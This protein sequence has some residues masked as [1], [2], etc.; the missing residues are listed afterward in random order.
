[1][2]SVA[3]IVVSLLVGFAM[4]TLWHYALLWWVSYL[5]RRSKSTK[6]K[7][8]VKTPLTSQDEEEQSDYLLQ[9]ACTWRP[10]ERKILLGRQLI[11]RGS[12][13]DPVENALMRHKR[14]MNAAEVTRA[15]AVVGVRLT[16]MSVVI[17]LE[18][19]VVLHKAKRKKSRQGLWVYKS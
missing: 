13:Y 9:R 10:S 4:A 12:Y 14:Y 2:Q 15:C 6:V 5:N 16:R 7:Q 11:L 19:L 1:M 8:I 17:L 3:L 18:A